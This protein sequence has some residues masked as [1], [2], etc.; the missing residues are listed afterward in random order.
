MLATRPTRAGVPVSLASPSSDGAPTCWG[1]ELEIVWLLLLVLTAHFL[2]LT[3]LPLRGE[4]SR[5]AQVAREMLQTGDWIVPRQQ[6]EPFLSRP[7]LGSWPIALLG[8]LRGDCD[9]LAVR[10]PTA[11]ATLLT[12][13]GIYGYTRTWGSRVA[14]LAAGVAYAT[15]GQVLELGRLAETEATFTLLVSGSLLGWHWASVRWGLIARTWVLG[16]GLAALGALAKGPQAPVYFGASVGLFLVLTG[17]WRCLLTRTHLLGLLTFTA[18]IA[19]WQLP[20][21]WTVGGAGSVAIWQSD[22][23]MRFKGLSAAKIVWHLVSYPVEILVCTLPWSL[24]LTA[25][26][27][28]RFRGSLGSAH[29]AVRFL[30]ICLGIGF[31]SCWLVPGARGRYLMPL[32]PCLAPLIGFVIERV[33][34][35]HVADCRSWRI[36]LTV[37]ALLMGTIGLAVAAESLWPLPALAGRAPAAGVGLC[38]ATVALCMA[39]AVWWGRSGTSEERVR[40]ALLAL[41]GFLAVSH[42]LLWLSDQAR[43]SVDVVEPVARLKAKLPGPLVSLGPVH[44]LFAYYYGE[45]IALLPWPRTA[46]DLGPKVEYF[47]FDRFTPWAGPLP[48]AWEEV[49]VIRCDRFQH[50]QRSAEVVIGRRR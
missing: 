25:Y 4:E 35:R 31:L 47:C 30:T 33:V 15:M 5:W 45:P 17:Q 18:V 44:H 39:T 16:Y 24:L 50:S 26:A 2:H 36:G 43:R 9:P 7:P 32:Y 37:L 22:T 46:A 49:A 12:T 6:G 10:L 13:L 38:F 1:R 14:A 34:G 48:F 3:E 11:L 29:K 8:L 20:F 41:G 40:V 19:A 28:G 23:A 42:T 27:S 21:Y